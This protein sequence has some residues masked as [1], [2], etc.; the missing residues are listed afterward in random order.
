MSFVRI[1]PVEQS[2]T[3]KSTGCLEVSKLGACTVSAWCRIHEV[4]ELV[5]VEHGPCSMAHATLGELSET[6]PKK[7]GKLPNAI[8]GCSSSGIQF[9]KFEC[10]TDRSPPS[11]QEEL[12]LASGSLEVGRETYF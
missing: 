1:A 7:Q 6:R 9:S 2:D 10:S 3:I 8:S 4:L 11:R 5:H 12:L